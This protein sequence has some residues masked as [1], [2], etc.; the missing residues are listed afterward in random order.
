MRV[1]CGVWNVVAHAS[2][3]VECGVWNAACG[4]GRV[5][6]G[7]WNAACGMRRVE[8]GSTRLRACGMGRG[9]TQAG[10]PTLPTNT[11]P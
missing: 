7:V 1:E 11:N 9:R 5:E 3:R 8:C 2:V 10:T 4:M 6:W